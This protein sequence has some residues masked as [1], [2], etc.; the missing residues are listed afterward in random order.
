[1][2]DHLTSK[3]WVTE[4]LNRVGPG[5]AAKWQTIS[6]EQ[7]IQ[8]VVNGG[9]LFFEGTVEGHRDTRDL[10]TGLRHATG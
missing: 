1:M 5:G 10:K 2:L 7:R 3:H 6:C 9:D 4:C 8:E